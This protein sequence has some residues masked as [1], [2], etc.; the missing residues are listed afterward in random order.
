MKILFCE[1]TFNPNK[2]D[3]AFREEYENARKNGLDILLYNFEENILKDKNENKEPETIIYRGWMT[4]PSEYKT[5]YNK[6]LSNNYKLINNPT[7]YQ[8]CHYLPDS[9][10]YI[11]EHTPKTVFQKIED[12]S[13][14]DILIEKSKIFNGKPVI[15]K[16]YVK[17][18]KHYWDTACY[19]ENSNDTVKLTDT[20]NNLI[21]IRENYL[22]EGIVI[23]E[24]V[25]LTNLTKHSKSA[26]PLSEEYRLFFYNNQLLCIFD[27]WEE[28][29]YKNKKPNT[30]EFEN[31]AKK[32]ESNFFTMDIAKDKNGNYIIIELGDGQVSGISK[33]EDIS[34][35]YKYL[36]ELEEWI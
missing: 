15:I 22:N 3:E 33:K 35:F 17:S 5:L 8:N 18:E 32:I 12:A 28:G 19:V 24:Y 6:L 10:K 9:L 29:D 4:T 26:M 23:R 25:E 14:I 36:G 31:I 30:T 27:Y 11:K 21:N 16:D 13:S 7:E 1:S 34:I 20:I 2:A